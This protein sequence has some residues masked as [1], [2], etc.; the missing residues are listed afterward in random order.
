MVT[1]DS[2]ITHTRNMNVLI[3]NEHMCNNYAAAAAAAAAVP[4]WS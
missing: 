4:A 2:T 3:C 1:H